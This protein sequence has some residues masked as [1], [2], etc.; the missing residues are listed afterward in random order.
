MNHHQ[1][2]LV[3]VVEDE[4]AIRENYAA[5]LRRQGY[6]VAAYADRPSGVRIAGT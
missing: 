3:A 4:P 1:G 2:K 6:R 5:G